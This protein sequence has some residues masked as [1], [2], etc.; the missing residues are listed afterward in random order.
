[1]QSVVI[2]WCPYTEHNILRILLYRA[3]VNINIG[4]VVRFG[5]HCILANIWAVMHAVTLNVM[6]LMLKDKQISAYISTYH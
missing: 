1:M 4:Y 6:C 2:C 5:I 3:P